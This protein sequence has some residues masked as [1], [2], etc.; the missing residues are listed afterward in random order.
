MKVHY[1]IAGIIVPTLRLLLLES[2]HLREALQARTG[3]H[4]RA[5]H[6]ADADHLQ[7]EIWQATGRTSPEKQIASSPVDPQTRAELESLGYVSAGTPHQIEL[8]SAAPDP[9]DR[10]D[11][12][13]SLDEAA[14]LLSKGQYARATQQ[15]QNC[16]KRDPTN[17][18]AYVYLGVAFEKLGDFKSEVRV[19][20]RSLAEKIE[21]D[22]IDARLGKAYLRLQQ[23]NL[24]VEAMARAVAINPLDL[25]TLRNLGTADLQLGRADEAEKAFKAILLQNSAL[26][27]GLQRLGSHRGSPR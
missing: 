26:R 8:E 5:I 25:D 4:Q 16:L 12:L 22:Q 14:A 7:R 27:R 17:P 18:L 6:P 11:L 20:Q 10:I 3:F 9:K 21:T 2:L 19:Y 13:K 1:R 23:L 15:L 24:G